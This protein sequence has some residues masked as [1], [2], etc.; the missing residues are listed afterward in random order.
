MMQGQGNDIDFSRY[1][2]LG[3]SITSGYA[4]G[5]LYCEGQLN[6]YAAI[7]AG[8]LKTAGGGDFK[9][10]LVNADSPGVDL[11]GHA[12]LVLEHEK[13]RPGSLALSYA[14]PTG[15][16]EILRVN[17]YA[18][19]GPYHNIGV[20][21]AKAITAVAP[22]F[23]NP[24]HGAGNYNPFFTRLASDPAKA[25]MLSDALKI[26]PTFFTVFIGNN[27]ALAFALS[28]GTENS[29]SVVKGAAG[30]GFEGSLEAIVNALTA[31]GAKGI[32][33]SLPSIT[34][35]PYFNAIPYNGLVIDDQQAGALNKKYQGRFSFASGNNPFLVTDIASRHG[36]IRQAGPGELIL[37]DLM[38]DKNRDA[39][40]SGNEPIPKK[41]T[42]TPVEAAAVEE[43]IRQYNH[44]IRSVA[45]KKGLGFADINNHVK[46]ASPDRQ[47]NPATRQLD[48]QRRGVFSLDGLHP[49]AFG[50]ALLA[51]EFIRVLNQTF[52]TTI[53]PVQSHRY[54]GIT[55]PG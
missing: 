37:L 25:S 21:G 29:M 13:D 42:L 22:G 55:F 26:R 54:K 28:G 53:E 9:Q 40:L 2:A 43:A 49:N 17:R 6:S 8:Q 27:D 33:A 50:Q 5:A 44:I 19:E 24:D 15:D 14:S 7:L 45:E 47:Y 39:C 41:Y 23:G 10:A 11:Q 34:N 1:V 12:R 48:Y 51:N 35:I 32:I 31:D 46:R 20:P 16:L 36:E 52:H 30:A 38:L 3:D 18:S 4:D